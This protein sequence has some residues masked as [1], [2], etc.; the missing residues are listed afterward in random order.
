[1]EGWL[2]Q[3]WSIGVP[4]RVPQSA[5][6]AE[7]HCCALACG[8][9]FPDRAPTGAQARGGRLLPEQ[10]ALPPLWAHG[11]RFGPPAPLF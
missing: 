6:H 11:G 1:M 2:P 5:G 3:R 4:V 10:G 7:V 8:R 9:G